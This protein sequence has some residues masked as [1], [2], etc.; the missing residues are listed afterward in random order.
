MTSREK[1][2]AVRTEEQVPP[3]GNYRELKG[4]FSERKD[5]LDV[6]IS[7]GI[8]PSGNKRGNSQGK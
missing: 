4:G 6:N 5:Q 3:K 8:T 1:G 2:K 7:A